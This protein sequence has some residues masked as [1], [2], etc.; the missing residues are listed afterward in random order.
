MNRHL[1][2]VLPALC[3]VLLGSSMLVPVRASAHCDGLD[4]PVV[5]AARRALETGDEKPV[6]VWVQ[7]R[8][9]AEI[10]RALSRTL[11]VRR[12]GSEAKELA[13]LYFFENGGPPASC[14]R[15]CSLHRPEAR[16][17]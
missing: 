11:A 6:L 4:G 15:R 3:C 13:D 10:K 8:D 9:G 7:E 12:L 2:S 5:N 1:R 14:G 17:P 16:R